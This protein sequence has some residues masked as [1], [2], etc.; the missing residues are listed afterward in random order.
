MNNFL[1]EFKKNVYAMVS[2]IQT[3]ESTAARVYAELLDEAGQP[4]EDNCA[5]Q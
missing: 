5:Q 2:L 3:R 1:C 4:R